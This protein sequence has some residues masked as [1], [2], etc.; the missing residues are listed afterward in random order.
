MEA[1][2]VLIVDDHPLFREALRHALMA[3]KANL[4]IAEAGSLDSLI[5]HL[6]KDDDFD[7]VMLDLRMPGVQ[8]LSGLIYLRAQFLNVPVVV[9]SASEETGIVGKSLDLG[10]SSFYRSRDLRLTGTGLALL[11][12]SG[13]RR[14][15]P[16]LTLCEAKHCA[17]S[18][19]LSYDTANW[20]RPCPP[21]CRYFCCAGAGGGL[22]PIRDGRGP[23]ARIGTPKC[24]LQ[25]LPTLFLDV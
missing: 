15:L 17:K 13:R 10:A 18:F 16:R 9:V 19:L 5:A 8:G 23:V 11:L 14:G 20:C 2:R 3:G 25:P 22:D 7:F 24:H 6:T 1:A 21:G 12:P 4:E